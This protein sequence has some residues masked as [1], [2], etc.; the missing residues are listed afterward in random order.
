VETEAQIVS[1]LRSSLLGWFCEKDLRTRKH[2]T[3]WEAGSGSNKIFDC[4]CIPGEN[5]LSSKLL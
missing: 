3:F 4:F 2:T 1:E 5:D